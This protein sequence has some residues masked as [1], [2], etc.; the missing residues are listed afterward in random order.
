M[1]N[2]SN[3]GCDNTDEALNCRDCGTELENPGNAQPPKRSKAGAVRSVLKTFVKIFAVI[4]AAIGIYTFHHFLVPSF[5]VAMDD[6]IISNK[7][8]DIDPNGCMMEFHLPDHP[9]EDTKHVLPF[10]RSFYNAAQVGDHVQ[11]YSMSSL[12]GGW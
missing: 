3:C 4:T 10:S 8:I 12:W 11:M 5:N 1:K 9:G 6:Y 7:A 2:C